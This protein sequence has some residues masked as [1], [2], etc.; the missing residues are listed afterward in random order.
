M[1]EQ[2][3]VLDLSDQDTVDVFLGCGTEESSVAGSLPGMCSLRPFVG[4]AGSPSCPYCAHIDHSSA[5]APLWADPY[6][7]KSR[8]WCWVCEVGG[9][10]Y[11]AVPHRYPPP[12]S[13]HTDPCKYLV[14][15]KTKEPRHLPEPVI[16]IP[17]PQSFSGAASAFSQLPRSPP[18]CRAHC[19]EQEGSR[20]PPPPS[21][22]AGA[23]LGSAGKAWGGCA[24]LPSHTL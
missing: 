3:D 8:H 6:P 20:T 11:W 15:Q 5:P 23:G 19:A 10:S 24:F 12:Q 17:L 4:Q 2:M 14:L 9:T 1:L 16:Q 18:C 22:T 7:P 13:R 21:Q